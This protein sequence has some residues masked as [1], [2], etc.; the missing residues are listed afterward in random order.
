MAALHGQH[1]RTGSRCYALA[2]LLRC[3]ATSHRKEFIAVGLASPFDLRLDV[4][5]RHHGG[6]R[7]RLPNEAAGTPVPLDQAGVRQSRKRLAHRHA[8]T[9]VL[10]HQLVF[11][12]DAIAGIPFA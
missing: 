2:I 12:W 9:V 3:T 10:S 5:N 8:R 7:S 1:R 6:L 11:E 4:W